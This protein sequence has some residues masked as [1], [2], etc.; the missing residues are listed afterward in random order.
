MEHHSKLIIYKGMIQYI[1][2]STSYTLK[3]IA[4]LSNSTINSIRSIY[5]Q[6]L[7]PI[8]FKS[9]IQL[10][11]LYQ[12]ILEVNMDHDNHSLTNSIVIHKI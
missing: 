11:K 1:L 2:D 10:I 7:F 6:N 3:N 8:D 9:E 5:C 4:E 12:I